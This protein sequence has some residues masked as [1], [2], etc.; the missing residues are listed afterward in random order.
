MC[1]LG[2]GG[3]ISAGRVLLP[4]LLLIYT[5]AQKCPKALSVMRT[6]NL[7]A[8]GAFAWKMETKRPLLALQGCRNAQFKIM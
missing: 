3:G 1:V 7:W 4:D 5:C 8:K 2:R 6:Q